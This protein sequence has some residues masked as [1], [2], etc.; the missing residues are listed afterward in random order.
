MEEFH[1]HCTDTRPNI[2][3]VARGAAYS[4][5][6]GIQQHPPFL[7]KLMNEYSDL[8][9]QVIIIDPQIESPP[10][11][12]EHYR[13]KLIDDNW[14]GCKNLNIHTIKEQF[15][16]DCFN[17]DKQNSASRKFLCSL[18]SRTIAAKYDMPENTYLPEETDAKSF[19]LR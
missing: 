4:K 15:E 11:I 16:F 5:Y 1:K 13:A 17:S 12:S 10:E 8:N 6:G 3:Y 9:F 2:T 7:E 19:P 18:I 14:Y